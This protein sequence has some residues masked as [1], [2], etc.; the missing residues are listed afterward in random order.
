[1]IKKLFAYI[2]ICCSAIVVYAI[3]S[4]PTREEIVDK[5]EMYYIQ[6]PI[7]LASSSYSS[8]MRHRTSNKPSRRKRARYRHRTNI[9]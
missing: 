2:I 9:V 7:D 5:T 4:I 1:M 3:S 6:S 8:R